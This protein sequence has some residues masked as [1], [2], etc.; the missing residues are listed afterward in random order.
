VQVLAPWRSQSSGS[1]ADV[2]VGSRIKLFLQ[3][4]REMEGEVVEVSQFTLKLKSRFGVAEIQLSDVIRWES[5][6]TAA[7]RFEERAAACDTADEWCDLGDWAQSEGEGELAERAWREA[8]KL[9]P[10]SERARKA[11]GEVE[12]EGEWLPLAEAM[13]RQGKE[14]YQGE[15]RTP[16]EIAELQRLEEETAK[17]AKLKGRRELEEEYRG[18]PWAAMDPIETPH[19]VIHCNSTPEVAQRYADVME[20][21]YARYDQVFPEK[22]FPRNSRAKSQVWIHANHQQFMDWTGN[23]PGIGG[24]FRPALRDVTAYHGSFGTTGSTEEVL[25]HEGTHQFQGLIFKNMWALPAWFIEGLAVYFGDGSKITRRKVEINVIPRDRLIGLQEAIENG[26]YCDLRTLLRIPQPAFG[27]FFYGHGWGVIYWCLYGEETGAKSKGIGRP[28]MDEWLMHCKRES[29]KDGFCDYEKMAQTFEEMLVRH[30]KKPLDEWEAEYKEWILSL[31]V[32]QV[33]KSSGNNWS[34]SALKMTVTRPSGWQWVK[35]TALA[36]DEVVAA[37]G[38]GSQARRISTYCWPNWQHADMNLEYARSLAGNIFQDAT[39]ENA[40]AESE[41]G[42]YP[43]VRGTYSSAKRVL[44]AETTFNEQGQPSMKLEVGPPLKYE[45]V[46]YG[47]IDKIYCNVFECDPAI[48]DAQFPQFQKWLES[49]HI[50]N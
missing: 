38:S 8:T 20:A 10:R 25:A 19:Y 4:D 15:W 32:E 6:R 3:G 37:K 2:A 40:F 34:S 28:L 26:S 1:I 17:A 42:G 45:V 39:I 30:A 18:R 27:G 35:E 11:L 5:F 12:Y 44:K 7:E 21:L 46:F 31:P 48:W 43:A 41:V 29:Q 13:K 47:S 23:G 9:E 33:G 50:D 36:S 22:F 24:F 16:E 49:F 14:Y